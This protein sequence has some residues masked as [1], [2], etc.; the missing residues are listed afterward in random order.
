MAV[1][2]TTQTFTTTRRFATRL[3]MQDLNVQSGTRLRGFTIAEVLMVVLII[4]LIAGSG[5]GLYIGTF[6]KM[7][8]QKAAYDLLLTAQYARIMA[9]EHNSKCT[10][11]L[12]AANNAFWLTRMQ[13]DEQGEQTGEQVVMDPYCRPVQLEGV[14]TFEDLQIALGTQATEEDE[15]TESQQNVVFLP[16]GSAQTAAI[17]IGNGKT[18]YT[19]SISAATGRAKL[20]SGTTEKVRITSTDLEMES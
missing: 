7:R 20:Y 10:L 17:Q 6:Q 4:G 13:Q 3:P 14:I 1:R 9:I 19:V 2:A 8:V 5:T 11:V 15:E 16:D 18:H 12:D